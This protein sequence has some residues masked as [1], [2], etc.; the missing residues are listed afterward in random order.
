MPSARGHGGV[1]Q[2]CDKMWDRRSPSAI[3][4]FPAGHPHLPVVPLAVAEVADQGVVSPNRQFSDDLAI[5][6]DPAAVRKRQSPRIPVG[7]RSNPCPHTERYAPAYTLQNMTRS[8]NA[9]T[10]PNCLWLQ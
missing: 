2:M 9:S 4:S 7:A 5:H 8:W 1:P 10:R 3:E 6:H